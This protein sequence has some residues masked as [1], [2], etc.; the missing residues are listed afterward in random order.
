MKT[1]GDFLVAA[2]LCQEPQNLFVARGYFYGSQID[3]CV[4]RFERR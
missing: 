1:S 4:T 3:H 2:T